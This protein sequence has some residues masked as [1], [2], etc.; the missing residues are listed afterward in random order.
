VPNGF[1][2]IVTQSGT[3][4]PLALTNQTFRNASVAQRRTA[5]PLDIYVRG[6]LAPF[7]WARHV[8]I[9]ADTA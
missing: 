5:L 9:S 7:T 3:P 2:L 4:A 1:S 6:G 8:G